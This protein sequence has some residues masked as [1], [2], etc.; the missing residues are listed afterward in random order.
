M[1][2]HDGDLNP[3]E[4]QWAIEH[5]LGVHSLAEKERKRLGN[6]TNLETLRE[7]LLEC[8]IPA[9]DVDISLVTLPVALEARH[10]RGRRARMAAMI[11]VAV[12]GLGAVVWSIVSWIANR[13]PPPPRVFISLEH[14]SL[15]LP[16]RHSWSSG[17][18][19]TG[20]AERALVGL[21][22]KANIE[23]ITTM[24][25]RVLKELYGTD[26]T[27]PSLAE[28][29]DETDA[30]MTVLGSVTCVNQGSMMNT[31]M[32]S[33]RA[34]VTLRLVELAEAKV[35]GE[36]KADAIASHIEPSKGCDSAIKKA[37]GKALPEFVALLEEI[38]VPDDGGV[39][40]GAAP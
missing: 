16:T 39:P 35:V 18:S 13:P 25:P 38:V 8:G 7:I 37:T 29:A 28:V 3:Q 40:E 10:R 31:I 9:A 19:L 30:T 17:S 22:E 23:V 15:N 5:A 26:R 36:A 2:M 24:E 32:L 4:L 27:E 20:I 6:A 12:I 14:E 11:F 34:T 1:G 21:F 33:L